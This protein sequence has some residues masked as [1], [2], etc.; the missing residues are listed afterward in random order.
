MV[1][2]LYTTPQQGSSGRQH[3]WPR[4]EHGLPVVVLG[5]ELLIS[6]NEAKMLGGCEFGRSFKFM[7]DLLP[8]SGSSINA[9]VLV[10]SLASG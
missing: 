8:S 9:Q 2:N 1:F 6:K 3:Y 5:V 4:G 7:L 10:L